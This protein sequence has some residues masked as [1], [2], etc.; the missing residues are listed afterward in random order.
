MS[1]IIQSVDDLSAYLITSDSSISSSKVRGLIIVPGGGGKT[2]MIQIL[3]EMSIP[4]AD[5]DTYW[6]ETEEKERVQQLTATWIEA[7][8]KNDSFQ[9]HQIEDEYVLLKARLSKTK[10]SIEN[11]FDLLF[12]QTYRQA[13]ILMTHDT[14]I[15]LNL[16]PTARLHHQNL[17]QRSV[18]HHPPKDMDVCQRQ[19]QENDQ[20]FPH[21]FYD[22]YEEFQRLVHLFHQYILRMRIN[23][24]PE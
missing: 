6:D 4:C 7:C 14:C 16:L 5:I 9:R 23:T 2:T 19:W 12:V 24:N 18:D 10:W 13:S 8:E 21:I 17:Y 15:T 20:Q 1:E 3:Q 11:T 22:N